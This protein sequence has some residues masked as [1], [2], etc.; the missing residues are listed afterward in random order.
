MNSGTFEIRP[1]KASDNNR[2]K[3]IVLSVLY[4][5]GAK[6]EGYAS[7]DSELESMFQAYQA[8]NSVY[9]VLL[10]NDEVVGGAGVGPLANASDSWCE[11][12]KMYLLPVARGKGFGLKLMN[13]CLEAARKFKYNYCYI[14]TLDNMLAAQSLY[15]K[16]GFKLVEN[17]RGATGHS[18]CPVFMELKL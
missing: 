4:A 18:S 10:E 8:S 13:T 11:L 12:Q 7:S 6:G 5:H 2:V 17:R 14:E 16:I 1:I 9:F 15:A 3:T